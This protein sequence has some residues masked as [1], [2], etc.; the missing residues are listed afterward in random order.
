VSRGSRAGDQG[1]G[2]GDEPVERDQR[3]GREN[4]KRQRVEKI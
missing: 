3:R 2:E 1:R 4:E